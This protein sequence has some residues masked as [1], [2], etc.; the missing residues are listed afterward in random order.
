M[1]INTKSGLKNVYEM[2]N[3][4][5]VRNADK[6]F[7]IRENETYSDFLRKVQKRAVLLEK[8]FKIKKGD[9]VALLCS[10]IPAF[11]ISYYAILS[12][13]ARALLL[14]TGLAHEEHMNMMKRTKAKLALADK[15][16]RFDCDV[17][18]FDIENDDDTDEKD[19]VAADVSRSDVAQ[20][21]FT[22][23]S[24]GNPKIVGITHG[25]LLAL[26]EGAEYYKHV[27]KPGFT[28]YGF[29]PLYHIYGIVINVICPVTLQGKLLLQPVLKPA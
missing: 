26:C 2:L 3:D 9:V 20:M 22:S 15:I 18:M 25:N 14:D 21:S 4:V 16:H 10:N 13:G 5:C 28:F 19:F 8:K 17:P 1:Q 24:T 29:L 6:I 12:I 11:I 27:A 23:G 7:F